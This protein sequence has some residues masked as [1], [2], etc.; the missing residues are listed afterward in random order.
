MNIDND[1]VKELAALHAAGALEGEEAQRFARLLVE[2]EDARRELASYGGVIERLAD[3]LPTGSQL[4]PGLK[5]RI[6]RAAELAKGRRDLEARLEQITPPAAGGFGYARQAA[7][8]GWLPLPVPGAF[9]KVL[10]FDPANGYATVLGKL[11]PGA[12]YPAH[13][14]KCPED[15]YMLEGDLHIGDEVIR[16]GDFHHAGAA[17]RHGVNWSENGCVLLAVLSK[18]DLMHQFAAA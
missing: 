1:Q 2:S 15:I 3:S 8:S 10:S 9:V 18:E 13:R 12:R 11:E 14:H 5:K 16:A 6:L 17:T 7:A 4:S